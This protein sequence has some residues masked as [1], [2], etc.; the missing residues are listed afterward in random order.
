MSAESEGRARLLALYESKVRDAAEQSARLRE[1]L[2]AETDSEERARIVKQLGRV[3]AQ[4]G[5]NREKAER[6]RNA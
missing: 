2:A 1:A 4:E 3:E 5:L 6:L